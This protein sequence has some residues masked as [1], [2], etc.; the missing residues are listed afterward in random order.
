QVICL[1]SDWEI[2]A[3]ESEK[4]PT[5]GATGENLAYVIY[6]SGSTGKPKGCLVTHQNVVRLFTQTEHWYHFDERDVW[7][8]FH[9]YAFDFSVWEIWG[10]LIYGGKLVVVPYFVSRSPAAFYQLLGKEKVTVLNQ[11]PSA[12]RQLIWAENSAETKQNLN[13]RYVIFGGEALELQSLK[14]WFDRH[15]D[16]KPQLVNMYGITETTVHVTY[17]PISLADLS[18]GDGSV[19]G[20]SIPDLQLYVLDESLKKVAVGV[21]GE[22][23]VGG[24]G[25]A[26]GYLNRPEL[27][28][29]RF[30]QN[31]FTEKLE[32][33]YR[34][35]D[36]ARFLPN[37]DLEYLG[38]ID[39]Q[40]K[41]RGFR[42][43]L[44]EIEAVLNKHETIRESIVL[45]LDNGAGDKQLVA[46]VVAKKQPAPS[47][48]ELR[49]FLKIKLPEYMVPS[50]FM[51]LDALPLTPN[52]KVDRKKLPSPDGA[53]PD[54]KVA[55]LA[56]ETASEKELATIWKEVLGIDQI[57]VHDN[58]FELGGDSIRSIQV[59]ARAQEKGIHFS[60]EKLFNTPT[61]YE[62]TRSDGSQNE[63]ALSELPAPF[64]LISSEDRAKL[65]ADAED[66]YPMAQLQTGMI[67][68]SEYNLKSAIFHDV[69]SF[70]FNV[71]YDFANLK[72]AIQQLAQRHTIFRTSFDLGNFSQ[73]LQILHKE[74]EVP[75]GAED[76]R[77]ST[78]EAQH[79]ALVAWVD[80][81][82]YH[83][84]DWSVAPMMRLHVHRY[85]DDTFQFIVSFHHIVMDGWS[86]AAMLTELFQDYFAILENS[87]VKIAAPKITYRDFVL[88]EK[89]AVESEAGQKFWKNKLADL[90]IHT[91]PRWPKNLCKGGTEQTRGPE[92]FLPQNI[93][94][95]LKRVSNLLGVPLRTVLLAAHHRVMSFVTGQN[96]MTS[97]L[98][99]NGRPQA[100]DG[101]KMIGLFLNTL[102]LRLQLDGGSWSDLIRLTFQSERELIPHR[103]MPLA[104]I[105]TLA[106]GEHLF[107]TTFDFVQFHVYKNLPCYKDH[108]FLEDYYFEANNFTFFTTFMLDITA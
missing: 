26:R 83:R 73:P 45:A 6:T 108:S 47:I 97:G 20:G 82:K 102:P 80:K 95:G 64:A 8:L 46:Y 59:L 60:L 3:K 9:S 44:G 106:G 105:Q 42:I 65:P 19:I 84:F 81:E 40:V 49:D 1:D 2:I 71:P 27:T 53:R 5:S 28:A 68:H 85:T 86:L 103:R 29:Q 13:L 72:K 100:I 21:E 99:A 35:G 34:T 33:L 48:S 51:F 25:V 78:P 93:F 55:F 70:R 23:Y 52:G 50:V 87:G 101:E 61:I 14:P 4:N 39:H 90:N 66:A 77:K 89:R 56:P 92:I 11:T 41:I 24:A 12:F 67:Y 74:V 107:E 91:L 88:L 104:A 75:F 17:R 98:V 57:G 18:T 22:M 76:L 36:L 94:D 31:P 38:R 30:I 69:F 62:L 54:L 7:S 58:F 32:R 79:E 96:D 37:G 16:K 15:G 63:D 43:E 10:A